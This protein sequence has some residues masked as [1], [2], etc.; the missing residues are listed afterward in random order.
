[1]AVLLLDLDDFKH[2]NDSLGHQAGDRMLVE[3]A[4][5]LQGALRADDT[6]GSGRDAA[7]LLRS[8]DRP[9]HQPS[10]EITHPR[11]HPPRTAPISD[12]HATG[13]RATRRQR[14]PTS[15][16]EPV[17]AGPVEGAGVRATA[18][19]LLDDV[20]GLPGGPALRSAVA[21][22]QGVGSGLGRVLGRLPGRR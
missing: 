16:P 15:A 3:V 22:L 12:G 17:A 7:E 6:A 13:P 18:V 1:M 5:R 2:I 4:A 8:A 14:S 11:A 21:G 9:M 20:P 19:D 10:S